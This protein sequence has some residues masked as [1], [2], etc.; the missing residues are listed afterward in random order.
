MT[1]SGHTVAQLAQPMQSPFASSA[2][3]YPLPF[4]AADSL[5]HLSGQLSMQ[6]EHPLHRCLSISIV[7]LN[8]IFSVF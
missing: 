4:T 6:T 5:M 7:P 2:Y 3:L 1:E 8:A